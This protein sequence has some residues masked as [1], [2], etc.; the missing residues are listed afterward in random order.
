MVKNHGDRKSPKDRVVRPL[1]NGRYKWGVILATYFILGWS[2]KQRVSSSLKT[3]GFLFQ[4]T[5]SHIPPTRVTIHQGTLVAK[6]LVRLFD[7]SHLS[8]GTL[9]SSKNL[10]KLG[11]PSSKYWRLDETPDQAEHNK[12]NKSASQD[13]QKRLQGCTEVQPGPHFFWPTLFF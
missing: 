3:E 9:V 5:I 13:L 10:T 6:P 4:G 1:P 7:I 2:S 11:Y 12:K 8:F